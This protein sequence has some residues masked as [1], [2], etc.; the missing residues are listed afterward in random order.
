VGNFTAVANSSSGIATSSVAKLFISGYSQPQLVLG[1]ITTN[2]AQI[3]NGTNNSDWYFPVTFQNSGVEYSLSF[4][5]SFNPALLGQPRFY[6]NQTFSNAWTT[7]VSTLQTGLQLTTIP[8]AQSIGVTIT[9]TNPPLAAGNQVIG[10]FQFT[11]QPGVDLQ[12]LGAL[13]LNFDGSQVGL[14]TTDSTG[15]PFQAAG[16]LVPQV[17]ALTQMQLNTQTGLFEQQVQLAN[18]GTNVFAE[19]QVNSRNNTNSP[20][21]LQVTLAQSLGFYVDQYGYFFYGGGLDANTNKI[22]ALEYYVND[23]KS[24]PTPIYSAF[25]TTSNTFTP[26]TGTFVAAVKQGF[27]PIKGIRT[28]GFLVAWLTKPKLHYYIE[29]T[30]AVGGFTG[31]NAFQVSRAPILGNGGYMQWIDSGPPNTQTVPGDSRFYRILQTN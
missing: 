23:R 5:L 10:Y 22:L 11:P 18:P 8:G 14:Q 3:A 13:Q 29:Y 24:F 19:I 2:A 1:N 7:N 17:I 16:S 6:L 28:S 12:S 26:P 4:T 27:V 25:G 15:I 30:D 9:P 31:T 21:G 20:N